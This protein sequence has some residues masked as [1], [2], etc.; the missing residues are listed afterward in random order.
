MRPALCFFPLAG[1]R[2]DVP[3]LD[4]HV[5]HV[6]SSPGG[7]IGPESVKQV[8]DE[9]MPVYGHS[10][11]KGALFVQFDIKF[12][13]ALELT[14]AQRKVLRG[15]LAPGAPVPP[16]AGSSDVRTSPLEDLDM[17]ARKMRERLAKD[18]YDS[19]EDQGGRGGPGGVRC[20]QQ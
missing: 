10:H 3:H 11:V 1:V 9:G 16:A 13:E 7:V 4:G 2:F 17:E 20:A 14:D 15:I 5:V 8:R 19:D 6:V 12:P 18:A